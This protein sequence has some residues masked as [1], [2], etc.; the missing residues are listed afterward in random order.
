M[1]FLRSKLLLHSFQQVL[2]VRSWFYDFRD[3]DI[4]QCSQVLA[5]GSGGSGFSARKRQ[6]TWKM[7]MLFEHAC[8]TTHVPSLEDYGLL[9]GVSKCVSVVSIKTYSNWVCIKLGYVVHCVY[10]Y[11]HKWCWFNFLS[12]IS[13]LLKYCMWLLTE[14]VFLRWNNFFC[15]DCMN[16]LLIHL[17]IFLLI[18]L[19][20]YSPPP[21]K[22]L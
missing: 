14:V 16:L 17:D 10:L 4:N 8:F 19:Y 15:C 22:S 3:S 9:F 13:L 7:T 20:V 21:P 12:Y 11:I 18:C 6:R 5:I 1:E 2:F